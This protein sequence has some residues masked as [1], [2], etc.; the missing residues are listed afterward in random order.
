MHSDR[1]LLGDRVHCIASRENYKHIF[2][3]IY[4]HKVYCL[5]VVEFSTATI[6]NL[7]TLLFYI[8][9]SHKKH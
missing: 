9:E 7:R 1:L 3:Y 6:L 4:D 2:A 5:L 8:K